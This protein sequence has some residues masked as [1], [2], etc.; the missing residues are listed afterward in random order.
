MCKATIPP[1]AGADI[2]P[3][4]PTLLA[5][6]LRPNIDEHRR[7][8][9]QQRR[10]LPRPRRTAPIPQIQPFQIPILFVTSPQDSGFD[11]DAM[12]AEHVSEA[13]SAAAAS[14]SAAFPVAITNA[15]RGTQN[16][17]NEAAM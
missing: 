2:S 8:V 3:V 14:A 1:T 17:G 6:L 13:V 7:I 9:D 12:M 5:L 16:V 4:D 15:E 11:Y 10:R